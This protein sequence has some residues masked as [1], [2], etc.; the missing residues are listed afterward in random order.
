MNFRG[1]DFCGEDRKCLFPCSNG[2]HE[3]WLIHLLAF[4]Q[5]RCRKRNSPYLRQ[6][7]YSFKQRKYPGNAREEGKDEGPGD[8]WRVHN[9]SGRLYQ[10]SP[11]PR[12]IL[13]PRNI[14][15]C[16]EIFLVVISEGVLPVSSGQNP[17]M[18]LNMQRTTLYNKELSNL[19]CQQCQNPWVE[20]QEVEDEQNQKG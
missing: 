11:Q 19:R 8:I 3:R 12:A 16:P 15:K 18:L 4:R 5:V 13:P 14:W 9:R 2:E 20:T 10:S 17:G 7:R 1:T 6:P